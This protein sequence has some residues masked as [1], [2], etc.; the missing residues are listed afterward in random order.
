MTERLEEIKILNKMLINKRA[1]K[2][3]QEIG[4]EVLA[5]SLHCM[6]LALC[7]LDRGEIEAEEDLV[8]TVRAMTTW[9]A[10]R[11]MNFL[12]L[13]KEETY[14]PHGWEK[15]EDYRELARI[16]LE[17]IENKMVKHFPWYRSAE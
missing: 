1:K 3:L 4:E 7:A 6:Q 5:D 14:D 9:R 15:A 8:Q 10:Q 11:I 2:T 17:D 13:M 12:M 16:I